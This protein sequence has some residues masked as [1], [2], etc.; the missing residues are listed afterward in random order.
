[1]VIAGMVMGSSL[2]SAI[3]VS[4]SAVVSGT[5]PEEPDTVVVFKGYASPGALVTIREDGTVLATVTAG[6]DARFEVSKIINPGI[7]TF[8]LFATDIRGVVS[9]TFSITLSLSQGTTTTIS[10]IFLGSTISTD[11]SSYSVGDIVSILG[12]TVPLSTV[13]VIVHSHLTQQF[14]V[15]AGSDG[16]WLKQVSADGQSIEVGSHSTYSQAVAPDNSISELSKTVSFAVG[17]GG[18]CAGYLAADINCDGFVNLIDFSI[19]L[20]YWNS[21]NPANPR[22]DI[23]GDGLVYI[24]DFSIMLFHWTG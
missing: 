3:D 23:N 6:P 22:A 4:I 8:T 11:R 1:M 5:P 12:S 9:S 18:S 24:V 14:N 17:A 19:M 21:R 15:N 13:S 10:G 16:V 7:Y 2:I 20:F